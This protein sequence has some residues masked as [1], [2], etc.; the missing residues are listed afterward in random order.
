MT[1]LEEEIV[2]ASNSNYN[3]APFIP[4]AVA[5]LAFILS[6]ASLFVAMSNK[7][8]A[9]LPAESKEELVNIMARLSQAEEQ[10]VQLND[11]AGNN[12]EQIRSVAEQVQRA[13]NEVGRNMG[14]LE[15]R[16]QNNKVFKQKQEASLNLK[17]GTY[18]LYTIQTGDTLSKIAQRHKTSTQTLLTLNPG[19][20]PKRLKVGQSI[21]VP[22]S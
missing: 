19:V 20:D 11:I 2:P 4:I 14:A 15:A 16:L 8:S 22:L 1:N 21:K 12:T 5:L 3:I 17:E 6:C 13:L 7:S 10:V 9:F 18:S